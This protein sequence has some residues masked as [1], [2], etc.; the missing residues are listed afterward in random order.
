VSV[1]AD[2]GWRAEALSKA[3]LLVGV[4]RA[5]PLLAANAAT[6]LVVD[7]H[8]RIHPAS[9]IQAYLSIPERQLTSIVLKDQAVSRFQ[10]RVP[11]G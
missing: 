1:V 6:G 3:A 2:E 4:E 7:W 10:I 9:G 8:G 11:A 5:L